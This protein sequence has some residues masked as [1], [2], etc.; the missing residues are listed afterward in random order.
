MYVLAVIAGVIMTLVLIIF[1]CRP[2]SGH[3][4]IVV[5]R[6]T[7]SGTSDMLRRAMGNIKYRVKS[8][9]SRGSNTEIAM[10]VYIP[11]SNMAFVEKLRA[12]D[13]VEDVTAIQYNGEYHD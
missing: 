4:Y 6:I 11:N 8:T 1:N 12:V 13:G 7:G 5:V 10:E 9:A 3:M 2:R